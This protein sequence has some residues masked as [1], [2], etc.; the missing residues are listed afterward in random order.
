MVYLMPR[1]K[2]A[3]FPTLE[4]DMSNK[5]VVLCLQ[6]A[7][8]AT[9][10]EIQQGKD[11]IDRA[12]FGSLD[13]G[14]INPA[15]IA[16]ASNGERDA[17]GV[18]WDERIHSST[19]AKNDNGKWKKRRGV[20]DATY[21]RVTAELKSSPNV[22]ATIAAAP[23]PAAPAAPAPAGLP[24][25]GAAAPTLAPIND[26][27]YGALVQRVTRNV[28]PNGPIPDANW[29]NTVVSHVTGNAKNSI[30]EIAGD[31]VSIGKVVEYINGAGVPA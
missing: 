16:A 23:A 17:D 3:T 19:K 7:L 27:G 18:T 9:P 14:P 5:T 24:V 30:A 15:D 4:E 13:E 28:T 11:L 22:S 26:F 10:E 21:A 25:P 6:I 29:I 20:D 8:S 31:A 12:F 1:G 2:S